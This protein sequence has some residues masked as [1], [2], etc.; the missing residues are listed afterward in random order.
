MP[1]TTALTKADIAAATNVLMVEHWPSAL[2][3]SGQA[4]DAHRHR[5]RMHFL[6]YQPGRVR[7]RAR[8]LVEQR[9]AEVAEL[10]AS[11]ALDLR[12]VRQAQ[13]RESRWMPDR[14]AD[15]VAVG[16]RWLWID[17]KGLPEVARQRG[18]ALRQMVEQ[19]PHLAALV[20]RRAKPD[21]D[22]VAAAAEMRPGHDGVRTWAEVLLTEDLVPSVDHEAAHVVQLMAGL[23]KLG[24]MRALVASVTP[25]GRAVNEAIAQRVE[26]M[27]YS[28][29]PSR[30]SWSGRT[31]H[32]YVSLT[33]LAAQQVAGMPP[34]PVRR[35]PAPR[36]QRVEPTRGQGN[37]SKARRAQRKEARQVEQA[38]RAQRTAAR[39]A[40]G[41][42]S[43]TRVEGPLEGYRVPA[44]F[45]T[46]GR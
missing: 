14:P 31:P 4:A 7:E 6:R 3:A 32:S 22:L 46:S 11:V 42:V 9:A 28:V 33:L 16:D 12:P 37:R 29:G 20:V 27:P 17:R 45:Y 23:H 1:A 44:G 34:E 40:A 41:G 2:T 38:R 25:S 24:S 30:V 36:R 43:F 21:D 19:L 10:S 13:Q 18:A 39:R 35:P 8:V 15:A 5:L 26:Q